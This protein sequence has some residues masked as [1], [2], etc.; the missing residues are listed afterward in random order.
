MQANVPRILRNAEYAKHPIQESSILWRECEKRR[1]SLPLPFLLNPRCGVRES[2]HLTI[3]KLE[4]PELVD[5]GETLSSRQLIPAELAVA[6]G[7][8]VVICL[9][10]AFGQEID[11]SFAKEITKVVPWHIA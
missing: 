8:T 3:W 4:F 9:K 1:P 11:A 2:Q 5:Q 6:L 7:P 10:F